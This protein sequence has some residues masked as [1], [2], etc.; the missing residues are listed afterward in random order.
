LCEDGSQ[1]DEPFEFFKGLPFI[2]GPFPRFP[3]F[4]ELVK[5][6]GYVGKVLDESPVEIDEPNE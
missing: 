6:F 3:F 2:S 1:G 5:G 4:G